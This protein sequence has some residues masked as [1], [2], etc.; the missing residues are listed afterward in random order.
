MVGKHFV[1][2]SNPLLHLYPREETNCSLKIDVAVGL[3]S[4]P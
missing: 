1:I 2:S 4:Y 3:A